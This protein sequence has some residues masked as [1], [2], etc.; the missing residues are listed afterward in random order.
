M[1]AAAS[2]GT[3]ACAQTSAVGWD[4]GSCP[5]TGS[6]AGV[7][8]AIVDSG[9]V[10]D[11]VLPQQASPRSR[12]LVAGED[13]SSD[14]TGHGTAMARIVGS[15]APD[16]E[17][18]MFKVLGERR[19]TQP[20]DIAEAVRAAIGAEADVALLALEVPS[21][22]LE[23]LRALQEASDAGVLLVV[24]AGNES[25]DLDRWS[26]YPASHD[27]AHMV[28]VAAVDEGG[29]LTAGSNWGSAVDLA[30]PGRGI[31]AGVMELSGTSPAAAIAAGVAARVASAPGAPE[32]SVADLRSRLLASS[33]PV[34]DLAEQ[35]SGRYLAADMGCADD[36]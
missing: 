23:L 3:V 10:P 9:L 36:R 2:A 30:A 8:V 35:A 31:R 24:A 17:I 12:S 6:G 29:E 27:V 14:P 19:Q 11:E 5:P 21:S 32:L 22:D 26:S 20:G 33:R 18:A 25:L 16:A 13:L 1:L 28:V 34:A 4:G 15:I 7:T